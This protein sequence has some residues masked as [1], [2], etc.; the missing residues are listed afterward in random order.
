MSQEPDYVFKLF[1]QQSEKSPP[2]IEIEDA[3]GE[4]GKTT[5]P[6][7]SG[8]PPYHCH[9]VV[10]RAEATHA[11]LA[12]RLVS[13][14][15]G[16]AGDPPFD[17]GVTRDCDVLG[18]EAS[19]A[20]KVFGTQDDT[21]YALRL[22]NRSQYYIAED[23]H[24]AAR[25]VGRDDDMPTLP[26][27]NA[28]L[29]LIPEE[30][31]AQCI[32][33]GE[34]KELVFMAISRGPRP[35][36]YAVEVTVAYRLVYWDGRRASATYHLELPV[37]GSDPCFATGSPPRQSSQ[38]SQPSPQRSHAMSEQKRYFAPIVPRHRHR[39]LRPIQM[40]VTLPGG[41]HLDVSYRLTKGSHPVPEDCPCS[42][43]YNPD[44]NTVES[45]FSSQDTAALEVT[46]LNDSGQHL[47]HVHLTNIRLAS[48]AD[49]NC[50]GPVADKK[51][52]D[53]NLLFEIVPGDLYYGHLA[54]RVNRTKHLALVTRGVAPGMYY[55]QMDVH[56]DIEQ[57]RVPLDLALTVNPD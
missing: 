29:R 6:L 32:E 24:V 34:S 4:G 43:G 25:I 50:P 27:G 16:K 18:V 38:Q 45:Y 44:S 57:C 14:T 42:Y 51:L 10:E 22:A 31:H 54:P 49:D 12:I 3:T 5:V 47:K 20:D 8:D 52:P 37:H 39:V 28:A 17:P 35:G 26:D 40:R 15:S 41:G 36:V 30:Q 48:V 21:R 9:L 1:I 13:A 55:V 46:L 7:P 23:V 2:A 19:V 11:E 33:P 53:G 56:Y